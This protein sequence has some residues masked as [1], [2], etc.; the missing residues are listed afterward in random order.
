MFL[1]MEQVFDL[2]LQSSRLLTYPAH[3]SGYPSGSEWCP[4]GYR[5]IK[6]I[7]SDNTSHNKEY[8]HME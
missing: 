2:T 8:A 4:D 7:Y 6:A 5:I 3:P 1:I